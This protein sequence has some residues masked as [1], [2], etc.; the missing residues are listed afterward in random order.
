MVVKKVKRSANAFDWAERIGRELEDIL[1]N[2]WEMVYII[3]ASAMIG[4][5][6]ICLILFLFLVLNLNPH[7][8]PLN[9]RRFRCR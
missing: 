7:W 5:L 1:L 9:E 2:E 4:S 6:W 8:L 3:F